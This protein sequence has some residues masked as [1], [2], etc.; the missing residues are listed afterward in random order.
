VGAR[1]LLPTHRLQRE[2]SGYQI[3]EKKLYLLSH[4][5]GPDTLLLNIVCGIHGVELGKSKKA[6]TY[7]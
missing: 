1:S 7:Y 4:L 6:E 5:S 3:N 2:N